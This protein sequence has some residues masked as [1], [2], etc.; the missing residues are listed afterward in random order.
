MNNTSATTEQLSQSLQLID[1]DSNDFTITKSYYRSTAISADSG[2]NPL[3]GISQPLLTLMTRLRAIHQ[4]LDLEHLHR[5]LLHEFKV[6]EN[7][8]ENSNYSKETIAIARY[9]LAASIEEAIS[10]TSWRHSWKEQ[11][12]QLTVN[13]YGDDINHQFFYI[14]EQ[15]MRESK[16]HI[17]LLELSYLCLSLGFSGKYRHMHE[18]HHLLDDINDKLF[19]AIRYEKGDLKKNLFL[20]EKIKSKKTHRAKTFSIWVSILSAISIFTVTSLVCNYALKIN[21]GPLEKRL[22]TIIQEQNSQGM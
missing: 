3:V 14:I 1:L 8:A 18:G 13:K 9:I 20:G 22:N 4:I 5:D 19:E 16:Q 17:E 21:T 15:L 2:V 11:Q 7:R 12:Y 10:T 6:F